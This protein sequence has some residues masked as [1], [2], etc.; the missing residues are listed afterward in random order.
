[1]T[2]PGLVGNRLDHS[3]GHRGVTADGGG[4]EGFVRS[5]CAKRYRRSASRGVAPVVR[6]KECM[7][8]L[9]RL[10]RISWQSVRGG[11]VLFHLVR[12]R[13]FVCPN[14]G[15]MDVHWEARCHPR[16]HRIGL[17]LA[18]MVSYRSILQRGFVGPTLSGFMID[19]SVLF[20]IGAI[21]FLLRRWIH[22]CIAMCPGHA[23][24][25][26]GCRKHGVD[27]LKQLEQQ[28]A[29]KLAT[30]CKLSPGVPAARAAGGYTFERHRH[31]HTQHVSRRC[32]RSSLEHTGRLRR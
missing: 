3:W 17:A 2:W 5:K 6:N 26:Q 11:D 13:V 29:R 30:M 24:L 9:L 14:H 15:P 19:A 12:R 10:R 23:G 16:V 1:M 31:R 25:C 4:G 27:A 32:G 20:H 21:V 18:Y 7:N 8:Q 22:L 28:C